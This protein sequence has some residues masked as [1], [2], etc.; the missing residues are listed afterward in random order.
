[1]HHLVRGPGRFVTGAAV[2]GTVAAGLLVV[3]APTA[4]A[5]VA[6][7]SLRS[8]GA[9]SARGAA[10]VA[11]VTASCDPS[12]GNA[13]VQLT[14]TQRLRNGRLV[15]GGGFT[16]AVQCTSGP[17]TVRVAMG[18]SGNSR[19]RARPFQARVAY[20]SVDLVQC[21]DDG[22]TC[23]TTTAAR[24]VRFRRGS[25][26][27][28]HAVSTRGPL[29][30][31]L[32]RS[33]VREADGAGITIRIPYTCAEHQFLYMDLFVLERTSRR[34]VTSG[35]TTPGFPCPGLDAVAIAAVHAPS[36]AWTRGSAYAVA[37][38]SLCSDPYGGDCGQYYAHRKFYVR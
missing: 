9:V 12:A 22:E 36:D 31:T 10:L 2:L 27:L 32:P 3:T 6:T 19:G 8:V 24:S 15:H 20:V 29:S 14:V 4:Q 18:G 37:N 25:L 13:G 30:L 34:Y 28:P 16:G 26:G 21:S 17:H 5:A 38:G 11:V 7:V 1:M 35:Y 23:T 33:A